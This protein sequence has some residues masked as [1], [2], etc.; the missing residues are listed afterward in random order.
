MITQEPK[1]VWQ[2]HTPFN[3]TASP[4]INPQGVI[5]L[6][7]GKH[8]FAVEPPTTPAPAA[9][10]SWPIWRANPQHTGRVQQ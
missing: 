8:I 6:N 4:N 2:F 7:D 1:P 9:T 5:Y 10:S 3:L